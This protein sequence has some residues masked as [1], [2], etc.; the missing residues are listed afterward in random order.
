MDQLF[1]CSIHQIPNLIKIMKTIWKPKTSKDLRNSYQIY[2]EP[3][4]QKLKEKSKSNF[5]IRNKT[6]LC[7]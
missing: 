6:K 7:D 4:E 1:Q 5:Q 2:E 3:Q